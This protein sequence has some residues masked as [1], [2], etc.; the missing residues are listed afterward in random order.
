MRAKEAHV[1]AQT[2]D[3]RLETEVKKAKAADFRMRIRERQ[4]HIEVLEARAEKLRLQS[5]ELGGPSDREAKLQEK[6]DRLRSEERKIVDRYGLE[7]EDSD[8]GDEEL[9]ELETIAARRPVRRLI[10]RRRG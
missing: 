7:P 2:A 10:K 6:I 1:R 8:D 5:R 4:A 9:G 3:L